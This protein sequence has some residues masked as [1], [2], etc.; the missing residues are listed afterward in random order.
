MVSSRW[1]EVVR[2]LKR[3]WKKDWRAEKGSGPAR[4]GYQ[5]PKAKMAGMVPMGWHQVLELNLI[6]AER[7]LLTGASCGCSLLSGAPNHRTSDAMCLPN[8]T[9]RQS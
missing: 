2:G 9:F 7:E 8:P 3:S 4:L 6:V 5:G 1:K